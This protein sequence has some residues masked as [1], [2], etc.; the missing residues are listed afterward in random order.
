MIFF[1]H[2]GPTVAVV[3]IGE[4]I[5]SKK[6]HEELNID[7]RFV[8]VGAV[9]P[10][11]IDKPIGMFFLRG[12]FHNSRLFA[13]SLI[14]AVI[15][16]AIGLYRNHKYNKNGI[17]MLGIGSF[18]HQ[19]L[20]SMWE[21]PRIMLWPFLGIKF[22][23]R[24]EGSWVSSDITRLISDPMYYGPELIGFIIIMYFFIKLVRNNGVKDFLK[25][26]RIKTK[27]KE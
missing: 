26:G 20:D 25:T 17:L 4:K 12:I 5:L 13:H 16:T 21:F 22:P 6:K 11:I 9:L 23:T 24:P 2:L 14:F 3:R 27:Y 7:Y 19:I 18:I 8:L 15:L 10:D 1:G